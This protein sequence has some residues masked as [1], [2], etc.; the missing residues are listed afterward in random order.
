MSGKR[1]T[2]GERDWKDRYLEIGEK[3][4]ERSQETN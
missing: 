3:A 1:K 2:W 4:K